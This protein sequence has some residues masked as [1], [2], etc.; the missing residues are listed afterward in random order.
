[1]FPSQ[2]FEGYMG[3]LRSRRWWARGEASLQ[4]KS[5][6]LRPYKLRGTEAQQALVL[7]GEMAMYGD[8]T[9][10]ALIAIPSQAA[11]DGGAE[12][13]GGGRGG[14]HVGRVRGRQ[15]CA[16]QDVARCCSGGGAPLVATR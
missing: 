1:M 4:M 12:G 16:R 13:A 2:T 14:G 15:Q 9:K 7:G 3:R 5:L 11:G 10:Q 6:L 8:F